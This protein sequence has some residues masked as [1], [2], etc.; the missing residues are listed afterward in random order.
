MG[1]S[2]AD[3][4]RAIVEHWDAYGGVVVDDGVDGLSH[5]NLFLDDIKGNG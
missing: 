3:G 5:G 1:T 2:I 4:V